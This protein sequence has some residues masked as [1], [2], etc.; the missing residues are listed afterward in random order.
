MEII[1]NEITDLVIK[2]TIGYNKRNAVSICVVPATE[3]IKISDRGIWYCLQESRDN[4]AGKK[5]LISKL[6]ASKSASSLQIVKRESKNT[7]SN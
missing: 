6:L 7:E 5:V 3:S 4:C 1:P 2:E